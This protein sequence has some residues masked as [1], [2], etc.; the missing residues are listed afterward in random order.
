MKPGMVFHNW[1]QVVFIGIA[2]ETDS[3]GQVEGKLYAYQLYNKKPYASIAYIK[4]P[5]KGFRRL[6]LRDEQ[7]RLTSFDNWKLLQGIA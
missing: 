3:Y 4:N 2:Q 6:M 5:K 7:G 1:R